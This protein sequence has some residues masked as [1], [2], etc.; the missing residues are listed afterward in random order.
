MAQHCVI[1]LSDLPGVESLF[2]GYLANALACHQQLIHDATIFLVQRAES[3][4]E[5][6]S[7]DPLDYSVKTI[8]LYPFLSQE[9]V[10]TE[11][12]TPVLLGAF[13]N[14][15]TIFLA[16]LDPFGA[17]NTTEISIGDSRISHDTIVYFSKGSCGGHVVSGGSKMYEIRRFGNALVPRM[18]SGS[19][20]PK[21]A[22]RSRKKTVTSSS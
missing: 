10:L 12:K 2:A 22:R 17:D 8:H 13:F 14:S 20:R 11:A 9:K 21:A 6:I 5:F 19:I 16:N 1:H 18:V 4:V 15:L 7:A 3:Q